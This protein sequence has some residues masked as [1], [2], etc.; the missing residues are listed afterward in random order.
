MTPKQ[1]FDKI[2]PCNPNSNGFK[3]Y[4]HNI[5]SKIY[6]DNELVAIY[7][8]TWIYKYRD[9]IYQFFNEFNDLCSRLNV[10]YGGECCAG[11]LYVNGHCQVYSY[12]D[13][14]ASEE[15][16]KKYDLI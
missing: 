5:W 14:E 1:L 8:A 4:H 10:S 6:R 13:V 3:E 2:M 15:L 11:Q 7:C 12:D 16:L 9:T